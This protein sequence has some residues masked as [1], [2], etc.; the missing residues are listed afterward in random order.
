LRNDEGWLAWRSA[1]LPRA[2]TAALVFSAWSG[3]R[4]QAELFAGRAPR[5][6]FPLGARQAFDVAADGVRLCHGE[7][8][9]RGEKAYGSY[10]LVGDVSRL[11]TPGS[12][13][14]TLLRFR[15]GM[16]DTP[17]FFVI[18]RK[19]ALEE[20]VAALGACLP[21]STTVVGGAA[22][23]LDATHNNYPEDT[24]RW[25]VERVF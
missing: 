4:G 13:V 18:D 21:P 17:M 16:N 12:A 3:H 6:T 8:G 24:G 22:E 11:G 20:T 25:G 5:L 19:R 15:T 10:A 1:P 9:E 14:D 2:G 23:V 7:E